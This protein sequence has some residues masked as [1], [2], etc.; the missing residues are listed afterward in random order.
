MNDLELLMLSIILYAVS[1]LTTMH[2]NY[3]SL[4]YSKQIFNFKL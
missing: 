3:I 2:H 1:N 4:L